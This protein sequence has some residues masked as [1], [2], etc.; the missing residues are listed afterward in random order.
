MTA[1][2][3]GRK[4]NLNVGDTLSVVLDSNPSTGYSWAV[5]RLQGG[6]LEQLGEPETRSQGD[7]LGAGGEVVFRFEAARRGQTELFLVYR[8]PFESNVAPAATFS[9]TVSVE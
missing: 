7:L 3:N 8:R 2:E 4:V 1:K 5:Q 6:I 9:V